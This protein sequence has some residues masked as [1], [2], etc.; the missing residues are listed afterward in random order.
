MNVML[1]VRL[2]AAV[3]VGYLLG[4]I[5]WALIIGLRLH[6]VDVR[7]HGSGN[8]GA[9]NVYRT[10]GARSAI[11]CL[12]L[13]AAKGSAAVA[14]AALIVSIGSFGPVANTWAMIL[15]TM[16]A[17]L[18]HSY[19]PYIKLRGGKG[20]ATAAG[21]LLILTPYPWPFLLGIFV[22]IVV[23]SRMVSLGSVLIALAYP[24]LC[25]IFYP[26]DWTIVG[27]ATVAAALVIWRHRANIVRIWRGE[28]PKISFGGKGSATTEKES[29]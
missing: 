6:N 15:A 24:V 4:G 21:A 18:G 19:S 2:L 23:T 12:L 29:D 9:T 25:F 11:L 1:A 7:Q 22:V 20:V 3:A 8:L 10:L 16:A 26:G 13:D 28:E 5:P 14:V 27:F 17:I